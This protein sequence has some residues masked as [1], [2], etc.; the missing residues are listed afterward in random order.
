MRKWNIPVFVIIISCAV[1]LLVITALA[2]DAQAI[3]E[4][5]NNDDSDHALWIEPPTSLDAVHLWT[6]WGGDD[7]QEDWWMFNA[8]P[9]QLIQINYRKYEKYADYEPPFLGGSYQ[10]NYRVYDAYMTEIYHY[11]K[12]F[13]NNMDD[14]FLRDMWSY[15][16]PAGQS[17]K[18]YIRSWVTTNQNRECY[19]WMNVT[20]EWPRDLNAASEYSG[21]LDINRSYTADYDPVDYFLVDLSSGIPNSDFVTLNFHKDNQSVDLILEVWETI[22]FGFSETSHMLNRTTSQAA[23]DLTVRFLATHTGTYTVRMM[24]G[25]FDVGTS[26]YT[27]T[28]SFGSRPTDPD[29]LAENGKDIHYVQKL[30]DQTIEMGYDTHD[31]YKVSILEGDTI[32]KVIVTIQDPNVG[33]GQGYEMVVYNEAGNVK[34]AASSVSQGPSYSSTITLPPTGTTTIFDANETLFVRFS[35]DAG[36]TDR[37]IKGFKSKYDIEFVL[38]NRPPELIVP[39]NETYEWYEDG[40]I[41]INLNDHFFDPDGDAMKYYLMNNT[42]K[43][44]IDTAGLLY[45]GWLNVTSPPN[46]FGTVRW[47]L[48]AQDEG[49]TLDSHKIFVEFVFVVLSVS[50]P[51]ISNGTIKKTCNEEASVSLTLRSLFYDVDA[52]AEGVLTFGYNDDGLTDIEVVLNA[53]TGAL[54]LIPGPDVFGVFTLEFY[55][56]D[57]Q[58]T[59]VLGYVELTVKAIN[60]IPR[61]TA[62]IPTLNMQEGGA[63]EEV[64]LDLYFHDV[65]NE[66]LVYKFTVPSGYSGDVNVYHKNN[67]ATE[68]IIIVELVDKSFYGPVRINITAEDPVGTQV[69]QDLLIVVANVPNPPNI[70]YFPVGNPSAIDEG[71]TLK[72]EVTD[73]LDP[74]LPEFGLHTFVW[75]VDGTVLTD[76]NVS[77]YSFVSTYDSAGT[78]TVGVVVTDPSGLKAAQEPTWTFM[79]RNVN[80]APTILITTAGTTIKEGEKLTLTAE[81]NDPDGDEL[82]VTW[83]LLR[84]DEDKVLGVGSTIN[85][86]LPA[87]TQSI[88]VEVTDGQGGK[89]TDSYS[90]KVT[91][92]E[93]GGGINMMLPILLIVILVVVVGLVLFMR[94]RAKAAESPEVGI[95]IESL[96]RDYDP[97]KGAGGGGGGYDPKPGNWE[98]YEELK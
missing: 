82:T 36:V 83:Y 4:Y 19:Y 43:F 92:S 37:T 87:G 45:G 9:G 79:V 34:Y 58:P 8:S 74:D 64:D 35:A 52:G 42:G 24:R 57:D 46:W 50:D 3:E 14:T 69:K 62:P 2:P 67:V 96:Q 38:T 77:E 21:T 76:H 91:A 15:V 16:V 13:D 17:E 32:F 31:W 25:F 55:C 27:L 86:K 20:V 12:T 71:Q 23:N 95:D 63:N 72:F 47:T 40:S 70:E 26:D 66:A 28:I 61:I 41:H 11:S 39:F 90:I 30:R 6:R 75:T 51:P 73:V 5:T 22:P 89:A 49:S 18:H 81:A 65:D 80:R 84:K 29:G 60:D 44:T 98:E 53:E 48:K 54:D 93:D 85:A 88:E 56:N 33:N 94:G 59:P 68:H 78:H 1:L 7:N 10:L 97:S